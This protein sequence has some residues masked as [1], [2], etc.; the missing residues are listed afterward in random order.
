MSPMVSPSPITFL[1]VNAIIMCCYSGVSAGGSQETDLASPQVPGTKSPAS[2]QFCTL[3]RKLSEVEGI[4][5]QHILRSVM[6]ICES[7]T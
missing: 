2:V 5:P 4:D 3:V 1:V 7:F 6:K